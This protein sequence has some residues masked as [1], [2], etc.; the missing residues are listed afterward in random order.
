MWYWISAFLFSEVYIFSTPST[1]NLAWVD[2][3]RSYERPRLNER[4][5]LLRTMF[6]ILAFAQAI[7][8]VCGDYDSLRIPLPASTTSNRH[9]DATGRP[10]AGQERAPLLQIRDKLPRLLVR[11]LILTFVVGIW[12]P[13]IYFVLLRSMAWSVARTTV[14]PFFTVH[15]SQTPSGLSDVFALWARYM[16][17][18]AMLV[19]LWETTNLAFTIYATQAPLKKGQPLTNDSK[20]PN[21]SLINGLRS[22]REIPRSMALWELR[23]ISEGFEDRRNTIYNDFEKGGAST[24]LDV[25][26]SC[27]AV[28][29]GVS[30]SIYNAQTANLYPAQ[31]TT[32]AAPPISKARLTQP[33]QDNPNIFNPA[34]RP[35]SPLDA[36]ADGVGSVA[37]SLGQ[38]SGGSP[39]VKKALTILENP[40]G[41]AQPGA[42]R[43]TGQANRYAL[44]FLRSPL[45]SPFRVS[46]AQRANAMVFGSPYSNA[47]DVHNAVRAL[48]R[49]AAASLRE[50]NFGQVQKDVAQIMRTLMS[51]I[52]ELQN[53]LRTLEPH[54]TDV[55][56]DEKRRAPEIEKL[57][58]ALKEGLESIV[59]TFGEYIDAL[60]ISRQELRLAKELVGQRQEMVAIQQKS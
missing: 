16:W 15:K 12:G 60:G 20:N 17:S 33:L 29:Q 9:W 14:R 18:A 1:A 50:D 19:L 55:Y 3:G 2:P 54:W 26:G 35:Q 25:A 21:G 48:T 36:I 45:G 43:I 27:M 10:V 8:H 56:F 47:A 52:R 53:L 57:L 40:A 7:V 30:K 41:Q 46:F 24:W 58:D 28:I 6:G 38:S 32:E 23:L 13:V 11:S 59:T 49:L 51:T 5:V 42:Q 39:L 22:K 37:K 4:A 31:P 34:P 44:D